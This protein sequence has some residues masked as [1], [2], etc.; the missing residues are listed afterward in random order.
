MSEP[1]PSYD[2]TPAA[3]ARAAVAGGPAV[4]PYDFEE[5]AAAAAE[6]WRAHGWTDGHGDLTVEGRAMLSRDESHQRNV[7][8]ADWH[9]MSEEE[10]REFVRR[11]QSG[12]LAANV[13]AQGRGLGP[14]ENAAEPVAVA[15]RVHDAN[16]VNDRLLRG[17]G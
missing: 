2:F 13:A 8:G 15:Q 1:A 6:F 16:A 4:A 7:S 9:Y 5:R 12:A 17:V 11:M 3:L 10:T 14:I